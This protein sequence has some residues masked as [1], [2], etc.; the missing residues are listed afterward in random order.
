MR[1]IVAGLLVMT[2]TLGVT[3]A[4]IASHSKPKPGIVKS[5][6]PN[7][8]IV[9]LDDGTRLWAGDGVEFTGLQPGD[10]VTLYYHDWGKGPVVVSYEYGWPSGSQTS[11]AQ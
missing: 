3:G 10:E 7:K 8:G 4:A 5:V 11:Q 1:K 9:E 2:F 6:D